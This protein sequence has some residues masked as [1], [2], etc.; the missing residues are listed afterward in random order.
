MIN[1]L[2]GEIQTSQPQA[3]QPQ[4]SYI[5]ALMDERQI[6]PE[7]RQEA[8]RQFDA[9]LTKTQASRWIEKLRDLPRSQD[10]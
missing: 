5:N 7:A 9:G 1:K 8:R 3:T 4:L 10:A 2:K 6:A